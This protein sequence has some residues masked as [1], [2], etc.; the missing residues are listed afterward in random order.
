MPQTEPAAGPT[1]K[2]RAGS[3][4]HTAPHCH[5]T[6]I[7]QHEMAAS[8]ESHQELSAQAEVANQIYL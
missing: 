6:F 3:G 5:G 1:A 7:K 2:P 8:G 4:C